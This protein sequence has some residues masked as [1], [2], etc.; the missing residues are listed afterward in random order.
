MYNYRNKFIDMKH[1]ATS[2]QLGTT[3]L[4]AAVLLL[5]VIA[6]AHGGVDD[7]D[8]VVDADGHHAGASEL[9][10]AL[11]A[12]WWGL[13]AV[14]TL[15]TSGLCFLVWKYLQVSLPKKAISA[16]ASAAEEKK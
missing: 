5:P 11:S 4:A 3:I 2:Q 14:A 10:V 16:T 8:G 12:R 9:L 1:I 6:L 7:G 13:L 15:L